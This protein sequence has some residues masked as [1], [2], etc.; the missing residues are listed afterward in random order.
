MTTQKIKIED[1]TCVAQTEDREV[2]SY[3]ASVE[4]AKKAEGVAY[5]RP[6]ALEWYDATQ[7]DNLIDLGEDWREDV[8]LDEP[9]DAA[10]YA[11]SE[12]MYPAIRISFGN[13]HAFVAGV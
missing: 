4:A 13:C 12:D 2:I 5:V 8:E 11:D 1:I 3:H 7:P 9:I 6:A 10:E